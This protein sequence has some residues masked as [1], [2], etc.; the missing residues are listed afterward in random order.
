MSAAIV[1][2]YGEGCPERALCEKHGYCARYREH[3][4]RPYAARYAPPDWPD[5]ADTVVLFGES[6]VVIGRREPY[7]FVAGMISEDV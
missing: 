5:L 7:D 6:A 4:I 2:V 1:C 3:P